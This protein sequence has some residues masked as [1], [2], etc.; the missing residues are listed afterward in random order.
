MRI[1][2]F[3][4]SRLELNNTCVYYAYIQYYSCIN[5]NKPLI[6][7]LLPVKFFLFQG[8]E[9]ELFPHFCFYPNIAL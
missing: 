4:G 2:S 3:K 6:I 1:T 5:G 9:Y 8:P 7:T